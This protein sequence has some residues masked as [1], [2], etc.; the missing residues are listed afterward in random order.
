MDAPTWQ[1]SPG[2]VVDLLEPDV[3]LLRR[4]EDG[5]MVAAFNIHRATEADLQTAARS[6]EQ[7]R[8]AVDPNGP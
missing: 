5:S 8:S 3:W 1:L 4:E 7:S 2:Y 6:D